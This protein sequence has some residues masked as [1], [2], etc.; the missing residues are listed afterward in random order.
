[1]VQ[2]QLDPQLCLLHLLKLH[3]AR[4]QP[5]DPDLPENYHSPESVMSFLGNFMKGQSLSE[6]STLAMDRVLL[7]KYALSYLFM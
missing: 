6:L 3:P 2:Q 1:M 4:E 5:L 7:Q